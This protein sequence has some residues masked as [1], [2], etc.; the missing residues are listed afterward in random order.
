MK[1]PGETS[2]LFDRSEGIPMSTTEPRVTLADADRMIGD[3]VNNINAAS[4]ALLTNLPES[5]FVT[6]FLPIF[7]GEEPHPEHSV[8]E[9]LNLW[10][11]LA[12]YYFYPVNVVDDSGAF[13][14]QVPALLDRHAVRIGAANPGTP[15]MAH[16]VATAQ[17]YAQIHPN[18]GENYILK[19]LRHYNLLRAESPQLEERVRMWNY[20]FK[21]YNKPTIEFL[22]HEDGGIE[23]KV[24]EPAPQK[25][26]KPFS[27]NDGDD[28]LI[29]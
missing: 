4:E 24:N 10:R 29:Y 28:E 16:M 20:I 13:L 18:A 21:R 3:I 9:W 1:E 23:L 5:T 27:M 17:Q 22:R 25:T 19:Q 6:Y 8:K 11:D 12:G 2:A 7:C 14:Y 26:T 15:P